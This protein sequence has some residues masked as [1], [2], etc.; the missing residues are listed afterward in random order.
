MPR[1]LTQTEKMAIVTK[2][3]ADLDKQLAAT[4]AQIASIQDQ[5]AKKKIFIDNLPQ[6]LLNRGSEIAKEKGQIE[7]RIQQILETYR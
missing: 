7:S 4:N 2:D 6:W 5:M 1:V 3:I